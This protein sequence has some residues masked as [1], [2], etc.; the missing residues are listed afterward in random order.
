GKMFNECVG[1]KNKL[2][3]PVTPR[4]SS[5][6]WQPDT[7]V[8]VGPSRMFEIPTPN[9]VYGTS[10]D[11]RTTSALISEF[12]EPRTIRNQFLPFVRRLGCSWC[13][14]FNG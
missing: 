5:S 8:C 12:L 7:G 14:K 13:D 10:S 4:S 1:K 6:S 2:R 11:T 9:L 3:D